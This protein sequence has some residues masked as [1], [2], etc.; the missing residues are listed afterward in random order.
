MKKYAISF[1]DNSVSSSARMLPK[2]PWPPLKQHCSDLCAGT[3]SQF[4]AVRK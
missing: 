2:R 3:L 1:A 4:S